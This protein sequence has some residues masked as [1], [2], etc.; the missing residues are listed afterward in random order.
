[1]RKMQKTIVLPKN[2]TNIQTK[3]NRKVIYVTRPNQT[4]SFGAEGDLKDISSSKIQEKNG[5]KNCTRGNGV[6]MSCFCIH[7]GVTGILV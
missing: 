6:Y 5:K 7:K 2:I 4:V 1:M 3:H